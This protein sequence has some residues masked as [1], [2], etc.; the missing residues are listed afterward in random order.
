M[1]VM[2]W[3]ETEKNI[4][5]LYLE[6]LCCLRDATKTNP[7]MFYM[8]GVDEKGKWYIYC[9]DGEVNPEDNRYYI[10]HWCEVVSPMV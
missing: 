6:V 4:P 5:E 3:I 9:S 8:G 1:V 7:D 10:S 2:K